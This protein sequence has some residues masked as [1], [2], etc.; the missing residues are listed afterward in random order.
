MFENFLHLPWIRPA[1]GIILENL[2]L[3]RLR[4]ANGVFC[5][6]RL[7]PSSGETANFTLRWNPMRDGAG[8]RLYETTAGLRSLLLLKC[9]N[10]ILTSKQSNYPAIGS[11]MVDGATG[12]LWLFQV[13]LAQTHDIEISSLELVLKSLPKDLHPSVEKKAALVIVTLDE[14]GR[15]SFRSAP[16]K[17][18]DETGGRLTRKWWEARLETFVLS[19]PVEWLYSQD[20]TPPLPHI[21]GW[22]PY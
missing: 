1:A 19:V 20:H 18:S 8:L 3:P 13:T 2:V 11:L 5:V 4:R 12:Q 6:S 22:P 9:T 17:E 21:N 15:E 16:L 7:V 10:Q 14:G